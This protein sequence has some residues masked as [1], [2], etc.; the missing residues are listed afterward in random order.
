MFISAGIV[1]F[2]VWLSH[3]FT[4]YLICC[5]NRDFLLRLSGKALLRTRLGHCLTDIFLT[6]RIT[7]GTICS[8]LL[9][10]FQCQQFPKKI[11]WG[12]SS[13]F[14]F[15]HTNAYRWFRP[16]PLRY[17]YRYIRYRFRQYHS[18]MHDQTK[19]INTFCKNCSLIEFKPWHARS[20][21]I[22]YC[23]ELDAEMGGLKFS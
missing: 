11:T 17:I 10:Q 13:H 15:R 23:Y 2:W 19:W 3:D 18:V 12:L 14:P 16:F 22:Y 9:W 20:N 1:C 6:Y 4:E 5:C 21:V 7:V 8:V